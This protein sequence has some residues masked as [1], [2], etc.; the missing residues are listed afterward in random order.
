MARKRISSAASA[1]A[2]EAPALL[3]SPKALFGANEEDIE[4]LMAAST[5]L[6]DGLER[7]GR[8]WIGLTRESLAYTAAAGIAMLDAATLADFASLA[9]SYASGVVERSTSGTVRMIELGLA[10]AGEVSA[11]LASRLES[12]IEETP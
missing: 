5:A 1:T 12:A 6:T 3:P 8:E 7:I 11:P 9:G 10:L 4:V 2:E